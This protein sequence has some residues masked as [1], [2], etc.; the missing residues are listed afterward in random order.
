MLGYR[1]LIVLAV[2]AFETHPRVNNMIKKVNIKIESN[3][4]VKPG[5]PTA[6]MVSQT[7]TG[8]RLDGMWD[9][10]NRWFGLRVSH[11]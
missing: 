3:V 11:A 6:S 2:A 1:T 9:P 5:I 10:I 8:W 7:A 4:R